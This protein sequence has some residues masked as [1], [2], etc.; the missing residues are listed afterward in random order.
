MK[1]TSVSFVGLGS[2]GRTM[3]RR[4]LDSGYAV[5]VWNRS[6]AAVDE[7]VAEGATRAGSVA[8]AFEAGHV[9]SMLADDTAVGQTFDDRT[10]ARA[11]P[12]GVHLNM[13]TVSL[14][15][16]REL[17]TRHRAAG[18]HYLSAPVLGRPPVTAAGQLNIRVAGEPAL[19]EQ[20]RDLLEA[21][22]K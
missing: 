4:L 5:T 20:N 13:A 22:G 21:L 8:E 2:M 9:L 7:L 6:P 1:M 17:T 15:S 14:A 11:G 10:L 16:A 12:S 19:I 3:V 18:V